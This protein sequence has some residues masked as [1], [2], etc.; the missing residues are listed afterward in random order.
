MNDLNP[1]IL[2]REARDWVR[3]CDMGATTE[4]FIVTL[5][6]SLEA[7]TK[8]RTVSTVEG[9]DALPIGA[10]IAYIGDVPDSPAIACKTSDGWAFLGEAPYIRRHSS[11]LVP[12]KWPLV[13]L[14]DPRTYVTPTPK[15][16]PN[17]Q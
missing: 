6:D 1:E 5:A 17:A 2:I 10:V 13:V 9:L 3:Q 16:A 8:P 15:G 7:A 14:H 11:D 4:E 12:A